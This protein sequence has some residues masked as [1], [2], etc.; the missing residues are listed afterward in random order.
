GATSIKA[1]ASIYRIYRQP[2]P[3]LVSRMPNITTMDED[4][5]S[6][7]AKVSVI[8]YRHE[9]APLK[10]QREEPRVQ[11]PN[12][13]HWTKISVVGLWKTVVRG[14]FAFAVESKKSHINNVHANAHE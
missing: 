13:L 12:Y 10:V 3:S 14:H 7:G 9:A 6:P 2:W 1:R 11:D 5:G 4:D 8:Y